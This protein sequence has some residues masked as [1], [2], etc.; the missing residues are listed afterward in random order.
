MNQNPSGEQDDAE[1]VIPESFKTGIQELTDRCARIGLHSQGAIVGLRPADSEDTP[2]VPI[3][4]IE[5]SIGDLAFS[6]AVQ[7]DD[8]VST[9]RSL[10]AME[11]STDE[12][13]FEA[14]RRRREERRGAR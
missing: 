7:N 8:D 12:A 14:I 9:D 6:P 2:P 3:A 10:K 5:F 11:L 4:F 13:E 1:P